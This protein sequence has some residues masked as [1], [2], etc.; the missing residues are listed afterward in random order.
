[1]A[2][3]L[4]SR[5][6][7]FDNSLAEQKP[8]EY[9]GMDAAN[10]YN[11]LLGMAKEQAGNDPVVQAMSPVEQA[12]MSSLSVVTVGNLRTAVGQLLAVLE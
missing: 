5:L 7:T 6:Q 12:A 1:M 8:G 11:A 2:Q 9:V 3:D 4:V 10:I